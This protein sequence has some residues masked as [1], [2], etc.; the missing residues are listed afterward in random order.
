MIGNIG[1]SAVRCLQ[2]SPWLVRVA[3]AENRLITKAGVSQLLSAT[4]VRKR[5]DVVA[6]PKQRTLSMSQ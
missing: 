4:D 3:L 6:I 2:N 1:A 5:G